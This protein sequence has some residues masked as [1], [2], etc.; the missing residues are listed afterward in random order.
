VDT[1]SSNRR[2]LLKAIGTTGAVG[3]STSAVEAA[4]DAAKQISQEEKRELEEAV[5]SFEELSGREKRKAVSE[6]KS[7]P[8]FRALVD[9]VRRPHDEIEIGDPDVYRFTKGGWTVTHFP[10]SEKESEV[11]GITVSVDSRAPATDPT[12]EDIDVPTSAIVQTASENGGLRTLDEYSVGGS[13]G[14]FRGY[15]D[16]YTSEIDTEY[17][18]VGRTH[19]RLGSVD[20]TDN[21]TPPGCCG[22]GEPIPEPPEEEKVEGEMPLSCETCKTGVGLLNTLACTISSAVACAVVTAQTVI[23]PLVCAILFAAMCFLL[24]NL[25]IHEPDEVCSHEDMFGNDLFED[26]PSPC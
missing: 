2:D 6:A 8:E 25:G 24:Y 17:G 19:I 12:Y 13:T 15:S 14:Q 5:E 20:S 22:P 7:D 9:A 23:G 26:H 10:L 3:A 16:V 18:E 1:G 11:G 4:Q 21:T